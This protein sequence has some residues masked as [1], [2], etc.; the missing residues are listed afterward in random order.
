MTG[1]RRSRLVQPPWKLFLM[2]AA[3][4]CARQGGPGF[5][6]GVRPTL[7]ASWRWL[8]YCLPDRDY[9]RYRLVRLRQWLF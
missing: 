9:F 1:R 4:R 6:P 2:H 3:F 5:A 7:A 8:R